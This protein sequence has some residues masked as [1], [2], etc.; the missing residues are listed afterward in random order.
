MKEIRV[1]TVDNPYDPFEQLEE[2]IVYDKLKG[3]H[4][5]ERLAIAAPLSEQLSDEEVYDTIDR[6]IDHLIRYPALNKEGNPVEYK[7]IIKQR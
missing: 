1:T 7:K 4:T 2:W 5:P 3:Y 6:G